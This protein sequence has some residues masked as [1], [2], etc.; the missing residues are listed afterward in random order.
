MLF[1]SV[2]LYFAVSL[3]PTKQILT[4]KPKQQHQFD[5][6]HR[7]CLLHIACVVVHLSSLKGFD[8]FI[9]SIVSSLHLSKFVLYSNPACCSPQPPNDH[10]SSSYLSL[11]N[12]NPPLPLSPSCLLLAIS[13]LYCLTFLKH[14]SSTIIRLNYYKQIPT[15]T[16]L[17]ITTT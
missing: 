4:K 2:C 12:S 8:S 7:L 9:L 15:T 14:C 16:T 5:S 13:P 1:S 10:Q 17:P 3:C 11:K 6:Q